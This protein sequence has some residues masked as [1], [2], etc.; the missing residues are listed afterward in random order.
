MEI[1]AE[2]NDIQ[3]LALYIYECPRNRIFT[4]FINEETELGFTTIRSVTSIVC[5]TYLSSMQNVRILFVI[6][7][8]IKGCPTQYIHFLICKIK[9]L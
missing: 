9:M 4:N 6:I 8:L 5:H 2:Q 3:Y 1:K 7:K